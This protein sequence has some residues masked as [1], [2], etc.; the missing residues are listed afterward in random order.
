MGISKEAW[1]TLKKRVDYEVSYMI[2]LE[3]LRKGDPTYPNP[4]LMTRSDV[5]QKTPTP[6]IPLR[7][8]V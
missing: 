6:R 1:E 3:T 5:R 7:P 8:P 4:S 2:P